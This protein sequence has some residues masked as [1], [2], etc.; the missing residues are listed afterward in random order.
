[1]QRIEEHNDAFKQGLYNYSM[2]ISS[3]ADLN[4]AEMLKF[5]GGF[6]RRLMDLQSTTD[7]FVAP[8]NITLPTEMDWRKKGAVTDVKQQGHCA[9]CW[10]FSATGAIEGTICYVDTN[11]KVRH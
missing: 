11:V 2:A 5:Y 1:M 10:A 7:V 8:E 9:S 4:E 3:L 6:Q